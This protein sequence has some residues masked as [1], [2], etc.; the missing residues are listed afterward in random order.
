MVNVVIADD[1]IHFATSLMNFINEKNSNIRV[2][3]ITLDGQKTLD[4]LNGK[5]NIDVILLEYKMPIYNGDEVLK[6]IN[7]KKKYK[8]SCII[9]SGEIEMIMENNITNSEMVYKVIYKTLNLSDIV[10]NINDLIEY[11]EIEKIKTQIE[12]KIIN[13]LVHLRYD[14][15]HNG[16]VYLIDTIK[17][18]YFNRNK[19]LEN[20]TKNVYPLIAKQH[21]KSVHN[22]K[23]SIERETREMYYTCKL[24]VLKKY[25]NYY[26]DNKPNVKTVINTVI[27]KIM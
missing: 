10:D 25:F 1:N 11:K 18:M 5:N 3:G 15:S 27:S 13:E 26:D 22:I 16:T 7:N 2:C 19:Y 17:Y 4:Y 23:C 14:I 8:N 24:E 12:N 9:I 20:L 6:Q 21:H